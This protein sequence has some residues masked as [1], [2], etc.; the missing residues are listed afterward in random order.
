[1]AKNKEPAPRDAYVRKARLVSVLDGDTARFEIDLGMKVWVVVDCRLAGI[2]TSEK[3]AKA[4]A[5]RARAQAASDF[6]R[7]RLMAAVEIV[8]KTDKPDPNDKFGRYLARVYYRA[9][10]AATLACLNDDLVAANLADVYDGG[11]RV[12]E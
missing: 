5:A 7:A 1:M 10:G 12:A 8:L 2:N 9:I 3:T 11:K 4:A 6:T